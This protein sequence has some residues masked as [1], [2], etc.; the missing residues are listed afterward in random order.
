MATITVTRSPHTVFKSRPVDSATLPSGQKV[1]VQQGQSFQ[2]KTLRKEGN[3]YFVSLTQPIAPVGKV[4]YFYAP[5]VQTD[6]QEIHGIWLTNID[7]VVLFSL[8]NIKEALK[9]LK[10]LGFNTLYPTVWQGGY[11]LYESDVAEP[12]VG[13]KIHPEPRLHGRKMLEELVNEGHN[14]GFRVIPWFEFGLM[15]PID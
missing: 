13:A 11:T 4:G 12:L 15:I 7:S 14:Q 10:E 1:Q 3:H 6:W 5:H 8:E 9:T 2:V